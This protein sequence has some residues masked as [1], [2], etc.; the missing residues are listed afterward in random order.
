MA[1]LR[2][3]ATMPAWLLALALPPRCASCGAVT[4][5]DHSF[6]ADCW[7]KLDFLGAPCCA[8]CGTPFAYDR[9]AG[10]RCGRCLA[11]PPAFDRARAAVAY[12]DIAR[13]IALKLK[14]GGRQ[15]LAGTIARGLDRL[16]P[17]GAGSDAPIVI[18]VPLHRWRIWSRGY[19][20]AALI[21]RAVARRHGLPLELDLLR[22][23]RATPRLRGLGPAGRRKAVRGAFA[24][25]PGRRAALAGRPV[26]LIDDVYT[27]GA[28]ADACARA[29]KRAG[30]GEVSLLCWARVVRDVDN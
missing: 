10:A 7:Q 26:V 13:R 30:A 16:V 6:C 15:G 17:A 1:P 24:V 12:G 18:P 27:T 19:N 25:S 8:C 2:L 23:T 28:T 29:L 20:Q 11:D 22:R 21:A 4:Q 14:Y 9:G 3:L 5:A